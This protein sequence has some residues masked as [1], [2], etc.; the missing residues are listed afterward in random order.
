[1]LASWLSAET[2]ALLL[3]MARMGAAL[4]VMPG[5]SA[6]Y[7]DTRVRALLALAM[8]AVSAPVIASSLPPVPAEPASL[9][10]I[11]GGE[12]IVGAF[13]GTVARILV[14]ALHVAGS[15]IA[16]FGSLA[17]ALVNDASSDQQ[18]STVSGFLV[19]LGV[20]LIFITD[21]HHLMISALAHSYEAFPA[22]GNLPA[23]D[24]AG[25]LARAVADCVLLG[26]Q[27][28]SPFLLLS[29][30]YGLGLGVL[31]RLMPQ[32][33]VFFFGLPI[34]LSMQLWALMLTTSAIVLAFLDWYAQSLHSF[35][36]SLGF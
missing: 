23:G 4:M 35:L 31:G 9:L 30:V 8:A 5:F 3:V 21:L 28:S 18:S 32:L 7:V 33:P 1:M 11:V 19:T 14:A 22:G 12:I 13:L 34:Q 36:G 15:F 27:L 26:L 2:F 25:T 29:F 24:L 17:N 6:G 10:L 16:F 20:V